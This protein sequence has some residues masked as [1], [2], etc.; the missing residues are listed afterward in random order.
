MSFVRYLLKDRPVLHAQ[1]LGLSAASVLLGLAPFHLFR[2]IIDRAIPARDTRLLTWMAILLGAALL[3]R[4]LVNF[5][6]GIV[7]ERIRQRFISRLRRDLLAHILRVSPEFFARTP[8]G[9]VLNRIQNDPGRLGMSVGWLFVDPLVCGLTLL[10]YVGYM[11]SMNVPLTLLSLALLPAVAML[12]PFLNRRIAR[13]ASQ[14][15][16]RLSEYSGSLQ[17][18][19]S[20]ANEVQVHGTF[21]YEERKVGDR[22]DRVRS[23]WMEGAGYQG[24]MGA[25]SDLAQGGGRALVYVCGALLA[26]RG[27]LQIGEI[28]AFAGLLGGLYP[29][30]DKLIKYP[31]LLRTASD[32][33]REVGEYFRIPRVFAEGRPGSPG[34]SGLEIEIAGAGFAPPGGDPILRDVRA[35]IPKGDHVALVGPSGCGKSTL[36]S[37]ICGRLVPSSGSVTIGG[38]RIEGLSREWIAAHVGVVTQ[39]PILFHASLRTN[40]LYALF[41]CEAPSGAPPVDFVDPR[42]LGGDRVPALPDLDAILVRT[43]RDVGLTEELFDFGLQVRARIEEAR[44]FLN[45]RES[46]RRKLAEERGVESFD[47][48]RYL[49]RCSVLENLLFAP[50]SAGEDSELP[51]VLEAAD[52]GLRDLLAEIGWDAIRR[53]LEFLVQTRERNPALLEKLGVKGA[54][55]ELRR[56]LVER[57]GDRA[58]T[59][60]SLW[61]EDHREL[62][63]R[64]LLARTEDEGVRARIV[65]ARSRY[66]GPSRYDSAKWHE[67][68]PLRENLVF[69]RMDTEDR[70]SVRRVHA[71]LREGIEAAG[72]L[73]RTLA[74]GLEFEVGEKGARLSGGQRQKVSLARVLLKEP[75]VLLLDEATASLDRASARHALDRI[76]NRFAGRTVIAVTHNL[77]DL[78]TFDRILVMEKGAVVD[79]GTREALL[80]RGGVFRTLASGEPA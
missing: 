55:L 19:L 40:L 32:R 61:K 79:E 53:D 13:N 6:Q 50:A 12:L 7:A 1:L 64:G 54:E 25:A 4:M 3:G 38:E 70:L 76:R 62:A 41:R 35:R 39:H 9:H 34:P 37:L 57:I 42:P 75:S 33:F 14:L 74:L 16:T 28:A 30:L 31:P 23:T 22:D 60:E 2:W 17:E 21:A 80:K 73:D 24:W 29:A 43:C 66:A 59:A 58:R 36:L 20:S 77:S 27:G 44:E 46:V 8:V 45:L 69:G 10:F 65:E 48:G 26:I 67:G 51:R 56:S 47:V 15:T 71:V 72:L 78:E 63:R 52:P 68:L 5:A 18:T 11:A 49:T